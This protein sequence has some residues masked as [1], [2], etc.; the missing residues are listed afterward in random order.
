MTIDN[1]INNL[2]DALSENQDTVWFDYQGF[3]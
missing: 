2:Y 3:R 1:V